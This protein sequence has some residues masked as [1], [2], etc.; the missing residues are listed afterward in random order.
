MLR[1]PVIPVVFGK[2]RLPNEIL[3]ALRIFENLDGAADSTLERS[4]GERE[5]EKAISAIAFFGII[6][7][8][9][10]EAADF[11]CYH[12]RSASE[13]LELGDAARFKSRRHEEKV[14]RLSNFKC[15]TMRDK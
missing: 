1:S 2:R 10:G 3:L 9:R 15:F 12:G 11:S 14:A 4:A 5:K 13:S 6:D 8:R 7:Q